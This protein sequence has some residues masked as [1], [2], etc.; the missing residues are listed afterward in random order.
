MRNTPINLVTNN[1]WP[2]TTYCNCC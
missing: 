2:R 1:I